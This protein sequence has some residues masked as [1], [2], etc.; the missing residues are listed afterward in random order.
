MWSRLRKKAAP[1]PVPEARQADP[2]REGDEQDA[3]ERPVIAT[4]VLQAGELARL[5]ADDF[6]FDGEPAALVLAYVAP[7]LDFHAI[8]GQLRR[9]LPAGA[10]LLAVS[11]AGEL[12]SSDGGPLYL[13]TGE[14]WSTVV[15]QLFSRRLVQRAAIYTVD[16]HCE[17]IRSGVV[18]LR[19]EERIAAIGREL[20]RVAPPFPIDGRDTLALTLV[21]G[22]SASE[23][24]LMEAV[25]RSGRFPCLFVGGSAGGA[26]DF[27]DTWMFD[28][29]RVVQ[30]VAVIAFLSFAPDYRF[31]L[32]R[33]HNFRRTETNFL[34]LESDL[35]RR[36]VS[37]VA[38]LDRLEP[39]SVVEALCEALSCRRDDL[40][41]RMRHRTLGIEL[42]GEMYVRSI[43]GMDLT[44]GEISFFCDIG[45]GDRLWLLEAEDIAETTARAF[46]AFMRGKPKPVGA[47]LSDCICRRLNNT[48]ALSRI[49]VFDGMPAAGFSTFGE[50]LG[51][52]INETLCAVVFFHTPP[53]ARFQDDFVDSLP[54]H[55]ARFASYFLHRRL[56]HADYLGQ[57]RRQLIEQLQD[58]LEAGARLVARVDQVS[59]TVSGLS[60]EIE[61]FGARLVD[62]TKSLGTY[63]RSQAELDKELAQLADVG[64][65]VEAALGLIRS[66][67]EQTTLLSLNASIEAAR[68]GEAGRG[69]AVVASEIRKLS[70]DTKSALERAADRNG[71]HGQGAIHLIQASVDAVGRQIRQTSASVTAAR[72]DSRRLEDDLRAVVM[73][74]RGRFAE[75]Q[76]ELAAVSG[77][78]DQVQRLA[79][80][81]AR[82]AELDAA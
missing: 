42:D 68:A 38:G 60:G 27:R 40:S 1:D 12:C 28:G 72:D 4:R 29:T 14:G 22:L 69:F 45:R 76:A 44:R 62:A 5:T 67:A 77:Y 37:L 32:L 20:E 50:L 2:D 79:S 13:P 8:C 9:R 65:G 35:P 71:G 49:T 41:D 6:A 24:F 17:D 59:Q 23:S 66:I 57:A 63:E 52:N 18:R 47:I 33:T 70:S 21:D 53:G 51:I 30:N 11:T 55:Y 19:E 34:V 74:A 56:A 61:Q 7:Q 58:E 54:A 73:V 78:N 39:I 15:L 43:S 64:H 80:V 46:S 3:S 82:L 81:A 16:L 26:M 36:T 10:E 31:G 75:L 48:A 25:Y